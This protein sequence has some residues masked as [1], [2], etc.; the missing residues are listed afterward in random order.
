MAISERATL[1][2]QAVSAEGVQRSESPGHQ[3]LGPRALCLGRGPPSGINA[4]GPG[5]E[6]RFVLNPGIGS[7]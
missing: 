5:G 2:E 1:A 4:A 7:A 3:N 6:Y